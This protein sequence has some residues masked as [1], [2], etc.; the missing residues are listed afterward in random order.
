MPPSDVSDLKN[1]YLIYGKQEYRLEQALDRLRSRL[2]QVADLD[3][4]LQT[5]RAEGTRA[6]EI[7][8]ACN[9]MPFMS[10][11]R[12][13]IV[14]D[15]DK[16]PKADLD[17]LAA[18]ARDPPPTTP[19]VLVA[20]SI[21]RRTGLFTAVD[22]LGGV[23]EYKAPKKSEYPSAVVEMFK[24]RGRSVGRDGAEILVKA[25]GHDLPR[26][27]LEVEKV[28]AFAGDARTLSR[29]DV[30]E[31]MSSTASTSVFELLDALGS[32]DCRATLRNATELLS[33]GETPQGVHAM[34]VRRIRDLI[35]VQ[36]LVARGER[37][38]A[39]AQALKRQDWQ[40][41]DFPRQAGRFSGGELVDALRAAAQAD[42]EM[43]TS[44]DPRL[45]LER[46]LLAVC[47]S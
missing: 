8:S 36:A 44:R 29:N 35:A 31:V 11:R 22:K 28:I 17:Q 37:T 13:V 27:S 42:A 6:E 3:F 38:Q 5:F 16:L 23:A 14:R 30:E 34:A 45:V 15:V 32:R 4:N 24:A 39:I 47:G 26:L 19:L 9:T 40:V 21:D 1:V 10:D 18:Y 25:V 33:Q 12:L 43:K 46:W 2:A 20:E 41:K 7:I